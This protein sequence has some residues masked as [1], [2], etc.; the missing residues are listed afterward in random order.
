VS[1]VKPFRAYRP[2]PELVTE[3]ATPPYDVL[4]SEEAKEM[5]GG[6]PNSFLHVTKSEIDLS[7]EIDHY[8]RKIYEKAAESFKKLIEQ[9]VLIQEAK[10]CF[11]IYQQKMGAHVQAGFVAGASVEEYQKNL[12]K[13]H[14]F[15]RRDKEDDRTNHVATTNANTGPVFL[16][17]RDNKMLDGLLNRIRTEKPLYDFTSADGFVHTVWIVD[18]D[19]FI[20]EIEEAFKKV[21]A[22]Y[23][24]DGHHRSAAASRVHDDRKAKNPGHTGEEG[25]NFFQAVIFPANQLYIMDYNRVVK[26]LNG[27]SREEFLSQVSEKFEVSPASDPKPSRVKTFGMFLG[28]KWYCLEAKNNSYPAGDPVRSLDVAILQ[29]NL[30][31]PLLGIGDPRSDRRIDFVGGIRGTQ[32]L[33]KRVNEG[34][35][36]AF[37][38]FATS[39]EQLMSVADAGMVMPPKSTWFEPK[40]RD[41]ILTRVLDDSKIFAKL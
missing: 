8:D 23:V 9:G 25:Y 14:E 39:M 1:I 35:A 17:Y 18:K 34:C 31:A 2:R 37:S 26:D 28:G 7:S 29:E 27:L 24:A 19:A 36:V 15:T 20:R 10:P 3:V 22:L 21:D 11:Y 40:L 13:K 4:S 41:G 33:E 5:A 12:I 32:E 30:L 6:N 38:M 16:A